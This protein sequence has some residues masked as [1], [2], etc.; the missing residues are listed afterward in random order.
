MTVLPQLQILEQRDLTAREAREITEKIRSKMGDL[1]LLIA[2]A[3]FGRVWIVLGHE[4]WA[5]YL[6]AEFDYA[7]LHLPRHERKAVSMFLRGQGMSTRAIA[8]ALGESHMTIQRDLSGV[9]NV[10]APDDEFVQ[11]TGL[12][13]KTYT[14]TCPQPGTAQP[15][16]S[17]ATTTCPTCGG[18][19]KVTHE[20][21][22]SPQSRPN[23]K[24]RIQQRAP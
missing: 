14:V 13:G 12:D 11:V 2:N 7:P 19:G 15:A 9:T 10:T 23:H 20:K 21:T 3:H 8:P 22:P 5:D 1:M 16:P 4:S 6:K 17:Q 18:T 24:K